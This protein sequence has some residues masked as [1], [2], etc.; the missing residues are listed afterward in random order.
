M[1]TLQNSPHVI[2]GIQFSQ[3]I[4]F[5]TMFKI[6]RWISLVLNL[7]TLKMRLPWWLSGNESIC[8]CR[9][10]GFDSWVGKILWKRRWQ[11]TPVFLTGKSHGQSS[12]VDYSPWGRKSWTQL[13]FVVVQL[14]SICVCVCVRVRVF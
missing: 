2:F 12:L 11:P 10:C 9:R 1:V 8:Q 13:R 4:Y 6:K 5:S 3:A 14:L 7:T